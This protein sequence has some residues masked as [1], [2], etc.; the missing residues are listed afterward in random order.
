MIITNESFNVPS[1]YQ[2]LMDIIQMAGSETTA[3]HDVVIKTLGLWSCNITNVKLAE[4]LGYLRGNL[5]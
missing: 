2:A 5:N 1:K 4:V 3:N